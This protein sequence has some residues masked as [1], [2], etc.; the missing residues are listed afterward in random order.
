MCN[1]N[2]FQA[3]IESK[4]NSAM[5]EN[6]RVKKDQNYDSEGEKNTIRASRMWDTSGERNSSK[7]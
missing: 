7:I 3:N 5:A 2:M 4:N 1:R 6:Q